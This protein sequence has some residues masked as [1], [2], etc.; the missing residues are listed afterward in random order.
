MSE[1]ISVAEQ[2][3]DLDTTVL[4]CWAGEDIEPRKDYM[5]NDVDSGVDY[6]ANFNNGDEPTH[7]MPLPK[8]PTEL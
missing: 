5:T 4:I 7:W 3:P 1:W 8:P 2:E 6:W